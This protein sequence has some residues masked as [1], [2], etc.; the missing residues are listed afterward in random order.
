MAPAHEEH[1]KSPTRLTIPRNRILLA[2][3]KHTNKSRQRGEKEADST[4]AKAPCVEGVYQE[5]HE[6]EKNSKVGD[7]QK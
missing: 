7:K 1:H 2:E 6:V 3:N 4:K 5:T